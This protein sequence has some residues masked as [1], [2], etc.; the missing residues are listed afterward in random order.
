M[1]AC[2]IHV[3][4]DNQKA[5]NKAGN[6]GCENWILANHHN[7]S[8]NPWS[9]TA[10]KDVGSGQSLSSLLWNICHLHFSTFK[11]FKQQWVIVNLIRCCQSKD[12]YF[13]NGERE[14]V[15]TIYSRNLLSGKK[16]QIASSCDQQKKKIENQTQN[17]RI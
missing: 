2:K 15:I 12:W 17:S 7:T 3:L 9:L 13:R 1:V 8:Y 5:Q 14:T 10:Y 4:H 16:Y 6:L 11:S